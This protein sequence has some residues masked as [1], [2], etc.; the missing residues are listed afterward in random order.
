MDAAEEDELLSEYPDWQRDSILKA[1]EILEFEE[2]FLSLPDQSDIHEYQ[3]MEDFARE[4][5][6]AQTGE[7][8]LRLIRGS[9]AFGR[10]KNAIHSM[11]TPR[12]L[13]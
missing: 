10:F 1:R 11:G 3:I 4:F 5:E 2:H 9:G 7:R 12:R 6:D 8:L 13:V